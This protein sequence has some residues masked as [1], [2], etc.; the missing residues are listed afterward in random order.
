MLRKKSNKIDI[1]FYDSIYTPRLGQYL[2]DLNEYLSEEYIEIFSNGY[3]SKAIFYN[4][5]IVGLVM[6]INYLI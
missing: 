6:I 4:D 1:Y 5:K 3:N 2:L